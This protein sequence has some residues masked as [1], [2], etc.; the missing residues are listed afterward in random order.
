MK[1]VNVRT[2]ANFSFPGAICGDVGYTEMHHIKHIRK[3]TYMLMSFW[4][5]GSPPLP[6][7]NTWEQ[8]MSLRNRK[9]IPVILILILILILCRNCHRARIHPGKYDGPSLSSLVFTLYDNRLVAS[10]NFIKIGKPH[11]AKSLMEKGW[12]QQY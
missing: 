10:E 11:F 6:Q 9:Q 7:N 5:G 8:M 12:T 4:G 2:E 3:R 1:W